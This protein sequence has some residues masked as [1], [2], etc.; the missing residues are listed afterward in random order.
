M[1][2]VKPKVVVQHADP[3]NPRCVVNLFK[4]YLNLI[5]AEE[6]F[7]KRPLHS[8]RYTTPRFSKQNVGHNT[9]QKYIKDMFSLAK[10]SLLGRNITNH[11][12]KVTLCTNLFNSGFDDK[13][14]RERSG[15][16]SDAI[17]AY[18]RPNND[19]LQSVS[20]IL[21]PPKPKK[22][23]STCTITKRM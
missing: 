11:S 1:R 5:P 6:A 3:T 18:K 23:T 2:K 15:H 20:N 9:L 7:Y 21:Q 10:I 8:L 16:R 4:T 22:Q 17:N 19:M 12:G 14:I 13:I